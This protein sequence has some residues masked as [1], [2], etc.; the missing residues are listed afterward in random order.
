MI[1]IAKTE[2]E[3]DNDFDK[4]IDG[5]I[6]D[7]II[8]AREYY[9]LDQNFKNEEFDS[10]NTELEKID[11]EL[12]YEQHLLGEKE[13]KIISDI[14]M[15]MDVIH[16]STITYVYQKDNTIYYIVLI[17]LAVIFIVTGIAFILLPIYM[18]GF[19]LLFTWQLLFIKHR[20]LKEKFNISSWSWL[21]FIL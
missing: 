3:I 12:K 16:K 10:I 14:D 11:E 20:S 6:D 5:L 15:D 7:N 4:F 18:T 2:A 13:E 21:Y 1:A 9:T 19:G 17:L 8:T